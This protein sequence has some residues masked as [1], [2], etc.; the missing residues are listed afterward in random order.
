MALEVISDMCEVDNNGGIIVV[1]TDAVEGNAA[2]PELESMEARKLAIKTAAQMG[3]SDPRIGGN[4]DI[5]A[6]DAKTGEDII[7]NVP[8]G[9]KVRWQARI[10]ITPRLV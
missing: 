4:V 8:Q 1:A 9:A 5:V 7:V 3:V 6:V 10:V 2:Y